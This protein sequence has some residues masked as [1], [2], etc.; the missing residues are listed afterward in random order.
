MTEENIFKKIPEINEACSVGKE[1]KILGEVPVLF[2][3]TKNVSKLNLINS[4]TNLL[5]KF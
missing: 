3:S 1:D 2:I 5:N 4:V